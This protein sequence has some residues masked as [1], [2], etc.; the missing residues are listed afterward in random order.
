MIEKLEFRKAAAQIFFLERATIVRAQGASED[1]KFAAEPT[2][3]NSNF[4]IIFG[5]ISSAMFCY[6]YCCWNNPRAKCR[7]HLRAG[8]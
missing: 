3:P 2:Q 4:S 8:L 5:I 7:S 1:K 6:R